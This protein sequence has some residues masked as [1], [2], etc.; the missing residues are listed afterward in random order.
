MICPIHGTSHPAEECFFEEQTPPVIRSYC[1]TEK[2]WNIYSLHWN[3]SPTHISFR[4][5]CAQP[6][7]VPNLRRENWWFWVSGSAA[8]M[9][10][11]SISGRSPGSN[12]W[13]YVN[14]PYVWPYFEGIFPKKIRPYI[15]SYGRYLHFRILEISHWL[16]NP[17]FAGWSGA[18]FAFGLSALALGALGAL[19]RL[20]F[21]STAEG[22]PGKKRREL[23][24]FPGR[25]QDLSGL[26]CFI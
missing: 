8:R 22:V 26:I 10:Q 21:F 19:R 7:V 5:A 20:E 14:V 12:W 6:T 16:E 18:T 17:A 9:F 24:I 11:R 25:Y 4:K 1:D 13:R 23:E 15:W 2:T 3:L